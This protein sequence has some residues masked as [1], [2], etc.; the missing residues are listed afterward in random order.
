MFSSRSYSACPLLLPVTHRVVLSPQRAVPQVQRPAHLPLSAAPLWALLHLPHWCGELKRVVHCCTTHCWQGNCKND[1]VPAPR[2]WSG[3]KGADA[4]LRSQQF[5]GTLW[6]LFLLQCW[7]D[8]PE[9][10]PF[11]FTGLSDKYQ[12]FLVYLFC[13]FLSN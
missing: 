2:L 12:S 7:G 11:R 3:R 4:V 9:A 5:K 10:S 8:N 13:F 6:V 1:L